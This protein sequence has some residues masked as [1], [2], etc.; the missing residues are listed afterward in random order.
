M[1]A[2]TKIRALVGNAVPILFVIDSFDKEVVA[3]CRKAGAAGYI[4]RPYKPAYV[5]AEI[6]RIL[7]GQKN[8]RVN[9][10]TKSIDFPVI[11]K[12]NK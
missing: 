3:Q 2:A 6:K 1:E 12:Y 9:F 10:E 11:K 8:Y 4:V 5:K 7:S